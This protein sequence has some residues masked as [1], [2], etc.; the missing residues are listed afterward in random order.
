MNHSEQRILVVTSFA[1][2]MSHFNMMVF[3]AV[4]L[5]LTGIL[6]VDMPTVLGLSF[7]MYLLFGVTALPW[8]MMGDKVGGKPLLLVMFAGAGLC[9]SAGAF[10]VKDASGLSLSL[11]GLGLFSGIYH[12][13]GMGL[14]SKGVSRISMAM[15]YNAVFGGLGLVVAP[16]MTGVVN[17]LAGP[18]AVFYSLG[19]L[20]FVG[21]L[22]LFLLPLD[23]AEAGSHEGASENNGM[24]GAFLILLVAMMLAGVVFSGSTVVLPAYL[25]L[26]G[27]E[28]LQAVSHLSGRDLSGNLVAA[29]ATS[30]VYV[31]G[32]VGQYF[33]GFMGERVDRR[34]AYLAFHAVCIPAALL[35]AYTHDLML[36]AAA[37]VFFFFHLG[38]Q[39]LENTLVAVFTPRRLHH[40]AFGLKFLLTFGVGSLGVKIVQKVQTVWALESVF[41]V[42]AGIVALIVIT[43]AL[44]IRYTNPGRKPAEGSAPEACTS[45]VGSVGKP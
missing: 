28:L 24:L 8:G 3:P 38:M 25:E 27:K 9:A 7:W 4:V 33:G 6:N 30:F 15:G 11:A 41:L 13:I 17:W 18:A 39:P 21:L 35:M 37:A 42:F 16:L 12:P 26:K 23:E 40:S 14:I 31:I 29:A 5:P 10:S 19:F 44:L 36:T 45:S 34:Y 22:L 1:H 43:A 2:F 32:M 20:N